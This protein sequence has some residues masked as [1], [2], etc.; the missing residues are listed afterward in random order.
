[1]PLRS[2]E[3]PME[4]IKV[5]YSSHNR[6]KKIYRASERHSRNRSLKAANSVDWF[7]G[8]E[9]HTQ[10]L[11]NDLMIVAQNK[12][13]VLI[14]GE[15]G[16][17]KELIAREIYKE[18]LQAQQLNSAEAPFIA[19]NCSAIPESLAESILFG[20]ERGAFTSARNRQYGKF[21]NA[22]KGILFLDEIQNL[23]RAI[24]SKLLRVIQEREIDRLGSKETEKIQ[25]KVLCASNVPLEHL[26]EKKEFRKDLFFR[27][28][29]YPIYIPSLRERKE[30]L[31]IIAQGLLEKIK[32]RSQEIAEITPE[33]MK[34]LKDYDWAGNI[35]ELEHCLVYSSLRSIDGN[36]GKR[37]L[38]PYV[39]GELA[40]Y[41]QKGNWNV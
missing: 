11:K 29:T 27:L 37:E 20:H 31:E 24:Q 32:N 39:T 40:K 38:P 6:P 14:L 4:K 26:V 19:I 3:R 35:R 25:C 9:K 16:C 34:I 21:E 8:H 1:M 18:Y 33:A 7:W 13:N 23:S 15:T 22:R 10:D 36:I 30:D 2:K 12:E 41:L 5:S 17:G 28:N